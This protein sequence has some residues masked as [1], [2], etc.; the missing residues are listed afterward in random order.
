[1]PYVRIEVTKENVTREQ[2]QA[3]IA[4]V[5]QLLTTVLQKDPA[6]TYVVIEEVDT[7]N[8]GHAGEQVSETRKKQKV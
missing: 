4:G 8:W 1:M 3:L 5:T 7:D 2:K 6:L